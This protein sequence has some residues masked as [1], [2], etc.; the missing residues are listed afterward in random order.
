[1]TAIVEF[2]AE[3]FK[4]IKAIRIK[5]DGHMVQLTGRNEQGK[6]SILDAIASAFQGAGAVPADAVRKG[7]DKGWVE[8][9]LPDKIVR[10]TFTRGKDGKPATT[11]LVVET[12]DGAVL[13]KPQD[14]LNSLYN[15]ISFDAGAFLKWDSKK[16]VEALRRFVRGVNFEA[17]DRDNKAD[18]ERRT[19]IGRKGREA[20]A[21]AAAITVPNDLPPKPIDDAALLAQ[22]TDAARHNAEIE[23][24]KARRAKMADAIVQFEGLIRDDRAEIVRLEGL[25]AK[26]LQKIADTEKHVAGGKQAIA[27]FGPLAS[28]TDVAE[29]SAQIT[30]AREINAGIARRVER[31]RLLSLAAGYEF[32][33][34]GYTEAIEDRLAAK[35]E[36]IASADMPVPGLGFDDDGVTLDGHPFANAS[37]A[38]RVRV[39]VAI[40]MACNP[41]LRVLRI[42]DGSLLDSDSLRV[43]SEM[44]ELEDFQVWIERVDESGRVGF[45]IEDGE[46]VGAVAEVEAA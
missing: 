3:N 31:D 13:K 26:L 10:R 11:S 8:I 35:R 19:D 14:V 18:A 25:I 21:A 42:S 27:E 41:K 32:R 46:V 15:D 5:P 1:M 7:S 44:A 24:E 43:V 29:V 23:A 22:M 38:Q 30:Q 20:N 39:A 4:K 16:Q 40:G 45:V 17:I 34:E 36:A 12:T 6:S 33:Y 37:G 9:H 28:A 2:R